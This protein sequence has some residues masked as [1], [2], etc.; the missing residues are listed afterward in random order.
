MKD[1]LSY[2]DNLTKASEFLRLTLSLLSKHK[3]PA[4]PHFY[5][6]GYE[7]VSGRN[8]SLI[9]DLDNLIDSSQ[10]LEKSQLQELYNDPRSDNVKYQ[11]IDFLEVDNII[12]SE[13]TAEKI[14][15]LDSAQS[16]S[17]PNI[18]VA[19][20]GTLLLSQKLFKEYIGNSSKTKTTWSFKIFEDMKK[21][22]EWATR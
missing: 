19:L 17:T 6:I 20:V 9:D 14:A 3:V 21:A 10:V 4:N 2:S 11:I 22:K 1:K 13:L 15:V 8:Q 7:Y 16:T 18:K 12:L 5:Q